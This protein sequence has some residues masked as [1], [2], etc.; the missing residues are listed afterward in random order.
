MKQV[1]PGTAVKVLK[2]GESFSW[3]EGNLTVPANL[4]ILH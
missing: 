3:P 4:T 1:S 2:V